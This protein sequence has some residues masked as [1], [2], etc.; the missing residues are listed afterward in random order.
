[1]ITIPTPPLGTFGTFKPQ[2]PKE[3][4]Y[5]PHLVIVAII[6]ILGIGYY[7]FFYRDV[8]LSLQKPILEPTA[9]LNDLEIKIIKLQ[10]FPFE[11]IDSPFYKSLKSYGAVPVVADSLGRL[12]PFV[13]Y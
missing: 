2:T 8:D 4:S 9:P 3:K 5:F 13:P 12:N 1:M 10:K 11:I 7:L 6:V